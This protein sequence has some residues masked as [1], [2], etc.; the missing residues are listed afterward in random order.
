MI[1]LNVV[2]GFAGYVNLMFVYTMMLYGDLVAIP[3]DHLIPCKCTTPK[4][5]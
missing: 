3:A 4:H 1:N 5:N 2:I